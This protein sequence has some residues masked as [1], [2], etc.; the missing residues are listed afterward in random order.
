MQ[1][2]SLIIPFYNRQ[3]TLP[4]TLQSLIDSPCL[5]RE[6]ILVDNN[7]TDNSLSVIDPY[8]KEISNRTTV[9]LLS[10]SRKGACAAR[11]MGA[12]NA[13]CEYLYFF[14]SDDELSADFFEFI[15]LKIQSKSYDLYVFQSQ[16]I[17]P[18]NRLYV[19]K[20]GFSRKPLYQILSSFLTTQTMVM[21]KSLLRK[22][23]MWNDDL[24]YWNDWEL[25]LRI[26]LCNPRINFLDKSIFHHIYAHSDSIT[27]NSYKERADK[28]AFALSTAYNDILYSSFPKKR[29]LVKSLRCRKA[30]YAGII[31]REGDKDAA[32]NLLDMSFSELTPMR[33]SLIEK[34]L[35][36]YV[37]K[38]GRGAWKIANLLV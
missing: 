34:L 5:P 31:K 13:S 24:F 19:R 1:G 3:D 37:A 33:V 6:V 8:I 17:L 14:D 10:C 26:L 21:K 30:I 7:S 35:F 25:G 32:Q 15:N 18:D 23:G 12:E 2:I 9:K 29:K 20:H 28:I 38:G 27:G 11:N 16:I 36:N 4:R 22:A